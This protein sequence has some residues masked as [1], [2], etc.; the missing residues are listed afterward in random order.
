MGRWIRAFWV[1]G[2]AG[3]GQVD[4]RSTRAGQQETM[5]FGT[6]SPRRGNN[7]LWGLACCAVQATQSTEKMRGLRYVQHMSQRTRTVGLCVSKPAL[8]DDDRH[9]NLLLAY[10]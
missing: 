9:P 2:C 6:Q 1:L 5:C 8:L 10:A 4:D 3:L 7:P